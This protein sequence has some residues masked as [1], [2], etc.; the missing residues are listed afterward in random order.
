MRFSPHVMRMAMSFWL[1]SNKAYEEFSSSSLQILPSVETLRKLKMKMDIK[2]GYSTE[3]YG[4]SL[5]QNKGTVEHG[6]ILCD[7]IKLKADLWWNGQSHE[8][9]GFSDQIHDFSKI[10]ENIVNDEVIEKEPAT[11]A[12]VFR[13]R[14]SFPTPNKIVNLNFFFNSGSLKGNELMRQ[15]NHIVL[16]CEMANLQV[17]GFCCD[18]GGNNARLLSLLRDDNKVGDSGWAPDNCIR[19]KNPVDATRYI[20]LWHC[21]VHVLKALRNQLYAS[22]GDG[23]GVRFFLDVNNAHI[24]WQPVMDAYNRDEAR[25]GID[26]CRIPLGAVKLDKWSVMNVRYAKAVFSKNFISDMISTIAT[27]LGVRYVLFLQQ[28]TLQCLFNALCKIFI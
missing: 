23:S 7:E 24:T 8:I 21:S 13:Y 22:K 3:L 27:A 19:C 17:H 5:D 18:A 20:Y 28:C 1:R 16:S 26:K 2:E 14:S 11:Y 6:H 12:N 15:F 9:I 4:W 25:N 10:V